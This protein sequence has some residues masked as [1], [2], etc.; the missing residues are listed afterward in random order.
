MN[1]LNH[2]IK[3]VVMSETMPKPG[4]RKLRGF[5]FE[6]DIKTIMTRRNWFIGEDGIKRWED[7][8]QPVVPNVELTGS[9]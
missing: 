3:N 5:G 1:N 2:D 4:I 6:L 9:R 8:N 7:N